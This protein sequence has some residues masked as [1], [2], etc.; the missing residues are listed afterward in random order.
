MEA[1]KRA[2]ALSIAGTP[3]AQEI[4]LALEQAV[5]LGR[6]RAIL[7]GDAAWMSARH[8]AGRSRAL[9]GGDF[10]DAVQSADG[11]LRLVIGEA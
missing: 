8:R 6:L 4:A 3:E 10:Y 2:A 9:L 11:P 1:L 5:E 7:R